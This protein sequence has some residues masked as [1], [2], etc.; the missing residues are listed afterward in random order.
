MQ[1]QQ[2]SNKKCIFL[3]FTKEYLNIEIVFF[4]LLMQRKN[5]FNFMLYVDFPI[6]PK[7]YFFH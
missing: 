7:S 3:K 2:Y 5:Y 1:L 4:I 6:D